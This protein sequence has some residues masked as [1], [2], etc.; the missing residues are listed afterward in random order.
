MYSEQIEKLIELA[1]AD[2]ELTEK[3]KQIIRNSAF[4]CPVY[5]SLNEQLKKTVHFHF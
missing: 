5:Q 1:L 3:E 2:G 4:T